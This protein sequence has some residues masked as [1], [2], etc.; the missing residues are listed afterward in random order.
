MVLD[1]PLVG[2]RITRHPITADSLLGSDGGD[3]L[4]TLTFR[5]PGAPGAFANLRDGLQVL[6]LMRGIQRGRDQG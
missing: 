5:G 1:L 3:P 2:Q 6:S 4:V